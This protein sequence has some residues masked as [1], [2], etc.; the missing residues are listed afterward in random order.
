MWEGYFLAILGSE[1]IRMYVHSTRALKFRGH[2]LNAI[3]HT[4]L[5]VSIVILKTHHQ[6]R[7]NCMFICN[8]HRRASFGCCAY[9]CCIHTDK[10]THP[11]APPPDAVGN[12][13]LCPLRLRPS[14]LS[15]HTCCAPTYYLSPAAGGCRTW[16]KS[17]PGDRPIIK[18]SNHNPPVVGPTALTCGSELHI[19]VL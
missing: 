13:L 16:P 11:R 6:R 10:K 12:C 5:F 8:R 1:S 7:A 17:T 3:R 14:P 15:L 2:K 4:R 19:A 9:I 18:T